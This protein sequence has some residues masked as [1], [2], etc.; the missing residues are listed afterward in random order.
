MKNKKR[1]VLITLGVIIIPFLLLFITRLV[2]PE[3]IDDVHP[4]I[5]CETEYI[6][7]SD[8][9][10]VIP[11]YLNESIAKNQTWCAE[12]RAMNK[13]IGMHGVD[14][15]Y[16]EFSTPHDAAYLES[17]V[18]MFEQCFG[19]KPTMFKAP[20]LALSEKNAELLRQRKWKIHGERGQIMHKVYHCNDTGR[21][22]NW[23][24]KIF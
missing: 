6:T 8:I 10:W 17:G 2:S 16:E 1:R 7:R 13:T 19:Y 23:I 9:L 15:K 5:P 24:V 18:T 3:E 4:A 14:H 22:K 11:Q 12:L 20:Q 21:F